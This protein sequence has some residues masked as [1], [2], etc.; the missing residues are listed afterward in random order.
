MLLL[1]YSFLKYACKSSVFEGR[2]K[3][4]AGNEDDIIK[5]ISRLI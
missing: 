4:G 3:K 5:E 1:L 2:G